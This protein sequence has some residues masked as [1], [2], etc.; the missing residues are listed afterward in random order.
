MGAH[1][2]KKIGA[3]SRTKF[4]RNFLDDIKAL[5]YILENGI[6]ENDIVSIGAEQELCLLNENW[7]P[8]N[9][10]TAL[11]HTLN[12]AHFTNEMARFNL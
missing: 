5:E 1:D 12:N 3:D 4:I 10:A 8:A 6:I 9:N 2:T 11:L 7:R